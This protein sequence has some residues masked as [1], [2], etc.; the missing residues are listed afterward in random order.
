MGNFFFLQWKDWE[1]L[2]GIAETEEA[3]KMEVQHLFDYV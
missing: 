3:V 2:E 1:G